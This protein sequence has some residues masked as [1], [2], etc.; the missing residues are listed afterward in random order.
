MTFLSQEVKKQG[1]HAK[2]SDDKAQ[3]LCSP[4][5]PGLHQDDPMDQPVVSTGLPFHLSLLRTE[6]IS[7]DRILTQHH[8]CLARNPKGLAHQWIVDGKLDEGL[9]FQLA[10]KQLGVGF[11]ADPSEKDLYPVPQSIP[12]EALRDCSW[13]LGRPTMTPKEGTAALETFIVCAPHGPALDRLATALQ[14]NPKLA[15]RVFLTT[16]RALHRT[17]M[18]LA[19]QTALD[20]EVFRLR[21][22]FPAMSSHISFGI[23]QATGLAVGALTIL[24]GSIVWSSFAVFI[25]FLTLSVFLSIAIL[26]LMSFSAFG[27]I[28]A[29]EQRRFEGLLRQAEEF[30]D[31]PSYAVLVPIYKEAAIVPDLLK[32][33]DRIDYP[34][35]KLSILLLVEADDEETR[36]AIVNASLPAHFMQIDVPVCEPRTKPKALN[37]ALAFVNADLVVIFDAED[38]P[39]PSQLREAALR[40]A[41]GGPSLACLQGRLAVDNR[42]ASFLSRQFAIEYSALFDGLLPF[43]ASERLPIPLGGT[44]NHFRTEILKR[45][46]GWDPYNVTEDADLGL[47]LTRLGYRIEILLS[48]TWEEAPERYDGW[49]RQRSRWFKGWMQ[50]WLIHMRSPVALWKELGRSR[51]LGFQVMIAGMLIS[52]LIH[53]VFIV[54]FATS[55]ATIILSAVN[56]SSLFWFL[57]AING[58]NLLLGYGGA[59]LLAHRAASKRYGFGWRQVLAMPLY[60]LMMTPAAWRALIQLIRT[61]HHWEKTTH[62]L[63]TDRPPVA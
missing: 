40:M 56:N 38:R 24:V 47:R 6:A 39:H 14:E 18:Q 29:V 32:A 8:L 21:D 42:D 27:K 50:T 60:W 55:I 33:L 45:I 37:Y 43:L 10:A 30:S 25:N 36:T 13:L 41:S 58:I 5:L 49:M 52:A 2:G 62:G 61:P 17:Q 35:E 19:S 23:I 53:P 20:T 57:I 31:W 3:Q 34:R 59:M 63:S 54:T 4:S 1:T 26:R 7:S 12:I 9:Y 16:S 11:I 48:E 15:R 46:G 22:S 28:T 51:F 44:S